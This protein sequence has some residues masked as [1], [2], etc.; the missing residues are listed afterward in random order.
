MILRNSP[1]LAECKLVKKVQGWQKQ[2][3]I[4]MFEQPSAMMLKG[5]CMR[6]LELHQSNL[7]IKN[8]PNVKIII[9]KMRL[10]PILVGP[11]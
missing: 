9:D 11:V 1:I 8:F 5:F 10:N 4:L 6:H 3:G 2:P 7:K